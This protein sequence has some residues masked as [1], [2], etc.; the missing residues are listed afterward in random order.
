[1]RIV[2]LQ[3]ESDL[4]ALRESWANLLQRAASPAIF[5]TWEWIRTWWSVYGAPGELR[6]LTAYDDRDELV[7]IVP[8]RLQRRQR[9][10]QTVSTL[11]FIGDGSNDSDYLNAIVAAGQENAVFAAVRAFLAV[12]LNR[13]TVLL[14]NEIPDASPSIAAFEQMAAQSGTL[15]SIKDVPCS[16]VH[17]PDSWEE[18]LT[19]LRPRFRTK[20]RSVLRNMESRSGVRFGFCE[21]IED[22]SRLL[23]I[24]FDLHTR[25]WKQEGKPGVF[26]WDRKR[27]FYQAVSRV[28]LDQGWLRFSWLEWNGT[29]LAAQYGFTYN[30]V[31]SQLQEG[32]EPDSEHWNPG[33]ALRAWSIRR[34]IGAGVREYDF[35]GGVGRH[36]SDWGSIVK[37]SKCFVIARRAHNNF[38]FCRGPEIAE[39]ARESLRSVLPETFVDFGRNLLSRL[40]RADRPREEEWRGVRRLAASCYLN[41]HLPALIRP[42]RRRY[43]LKVSGDAWRQ[44]P[45]VKR[46]RPSAR[47]L[48]YHRVNDDRDPFF[49]S[50][51]TRVFREHMRFIAKY[52]NVVSLD[53]LPAR[54]DDRS[55]DPLLA[56]TFDDGYEDNYRN[57]FP[58]LR[59]YNLPAT[60]FLTTGSIDS[61]EPLW[62]EQLATALKRT[63]REFLDLEIDIPRRFWLRNQ[64][65]RLHANAGIFRL[66]RTLPDASRRDW[67]AIICRALAADVISERRKKMLAWDQIRI[68]ER[69]N[70]SFG[71]HTV[72]HPFLSKLTEENVRW[73]V[74]ECKRRIEEELDH[75]IHHFSYPNGREEDFGMW[76]KEAIRRAGYHNAVTTIW[77]MNYPDTD[78]M[79]LRRGGP[80]EQNLAQFASK[81]DWYQLVND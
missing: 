75:P 72:T 22:V 9:F 76:N 14:L 45:W 62:F 10:G 39:Q 21:T 33:V 60:V 59:D 50:M 61:G 40:S 71:G 68:M 30:G 27:H 55:S 17:L 5:V 20:V 38:L 74:G 3:R 79:E 77:G 12:D 47:I 29:I 51:P 36:K 6:V 81:L 49:S 26:G 73:E 57:A 8:L 19:V 7:G 41:L 52:Y 35:L 4:E 67:L 13:G 25:R 24:L 2:L 44:L 28:L 43:Q 65:E 54:L 48:Y 37:E 63:D 78:P 34:L 11:S 56:I 66:F 42:I 80:W 64:S 31:Y 46:Q 16:T 58:I 70:I 32:Y 1:M 53:E 69:E 23:P 18:Y 15:T